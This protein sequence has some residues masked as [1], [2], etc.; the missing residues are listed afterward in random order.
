MQSNRIQYALVSAIQFMNY[1]S[2]LVTRSVLSYKD[3]GRSS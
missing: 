3:K 2:K 1:F